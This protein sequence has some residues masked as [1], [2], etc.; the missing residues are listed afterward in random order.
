MINIKDYPLFIPPEEVNSKKPREW[1]YE[2]AKM[3]FDWFMSVKDDRV[4]YLLTVFDEE[5]ACD[6]EKY[7]KRIGQ[8]VF[9]V[10][11]KEPF[12]TDESSGKAITNRGLALAA[13][14]AL[15][16]AK[17]IMQKYPGIKWNIVKSPKSDVSFHLPALFKFPKLGHIET[18]GG[19]IAN[20][21]AI[22][23]G[24]ETYDIW[25]KMFKYADDILKKVN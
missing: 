10:L 19:S 6:N 15:L 23:R 5:V 17:L 3:Y 4:E 2:E 11:H 22:L 8:K 9:D 25:W 7:L 13:D 14:M 21:K 12:S 16:V 20:S 18:I 24:E 1:S